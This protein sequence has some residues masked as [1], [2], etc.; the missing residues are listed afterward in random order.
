MYNSS[1]KPDASKHFSKVSRIIAVNSFSNFDFTKDLQNLSY[2]S[3]YHST[4]IM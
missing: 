1:K 2:F 4:S 3:R